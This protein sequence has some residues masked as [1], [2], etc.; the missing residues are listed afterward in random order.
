MESLKHLF[1]WRRL[2]KRYDLKLLRRDALILAVL[3]GLGFAVKTAYR[4][5]REYKLDR[6]LEA[7]KV[8]ARVE[9]WGAA[10]D[11]A[12]SVLIAR[13]GDFEAFRIWFQALAHLNEPRT[14]LVAAAL[15]TDPRSSREVRMDALRVLAK[16]APQ[17]VT[18][19]AYASLGKDLQHE[20]AALAAIAPLLI[21]RG[22][23][24]YVEKVL[25]ASPALASDPEIQLELLRSLC[26]RPSVE[27]VAEART[28][29][30]GLVKA[31]AS[32]PAL[33]ALRLLGE[34]PGGLAPGPPLP[35]LPEWVKVQPKA[36]TLHHLLALQ[37]AIEASPATAESVFQQAITRFLGTDP[38]T[39]GDWLIRHDQAARVAELLAEPAQTSATAFISRLHALLLLKNNA[40]I[41]AALSAPPASCDPVGL[42]LVKAAVARLH[43]DVAAETSAWTRALDQATFDQSR[44]RC[45]EIVRY[46]ELLKASKVADDA[47]VAAIRVGWG[48]IP[49]YADLR[50]LYASL[51]A[52]GRSEDLLAVYASLLRF[53]PYTPELLNNYYYLA[54]LHG[55]VTPAAATTALGNLVAANP[56]ATEFLP[57]LAMAYLS[58]DQPIPALQLLPAM[59]E[60]KRINPVAWKA[61]GGTALFLTG[62][63]AAAENLLNGL[64]WSI[65]MNCERV[66][67]RRLLR[68]QKL[69]DVPLP[70]VTTPKVLDDNEI[71]A[72]RKAV[73][74]LEKARQHDVLPPLPAPKI[75]GADQPESANPVSSQPAQ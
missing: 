5:Y 25:R 69:K 63:V 15:F 8:A 14:Y 30:A 44:N 51:A 70:V 72:W 34:T 37:P 27:R 48:P 2:R 42:E 3:I 65:F 46:A 68:D 31:D 57:A 13:A 9:D 18:L 55:V 11:L 53:E 58:N 52:Q 6:N 75:P 61:M 38:G 7:A 33:E 20:P 67:F 40:E 10:R 59:K 36:T 64:D 22:E 1:K 21:Q 73:E 24:A 12:R 16:Q 17:A 47:W 62:D 60:S 74:R 29:F 39:L 43:G 49:L 50:K 4:A 45:F 71:P 66:A 54:L 56:Q 19:S 23:T 32:E 28:L 35:P 26:S 41:T